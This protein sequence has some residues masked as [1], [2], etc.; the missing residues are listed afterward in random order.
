VRAA[1]RALDWYNDERLARVTATT[2][3]DS[4]SAHRMLGLALL[5]AGDQQAA[6]EEFGRALAIAPNDVVSLYQSA[7]IFQGAQRDIQALTLYRRTVDTDPTFLPGWLGLA[8]TNRESG[9]Y[10]PSLSNADKV[11]ELRP[12]LPHGYVA[13]GLAQA[14]L[15]RKEEARAS[16][17]RAVQVAPTFPEAL[18]AL[19][20][21]G[22]RE[23]DAA[24]AA[25]AFE[26]LVAVAPSA[27]AY[28]ALVASY[29]SAGRGEDADRAAAAARQRFP[30]DPAFAP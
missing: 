2:A 12:D 23:G 24:L 7:L 9:R 4:V 11:V 28:K 27:D 8:R 21:F 10:A 22:M 19:G 29:R 14:A 30:D 25:G 13:R 17:E 18:I 3:P 6:I 26:K 16:L 1:Y 15:D 5:G 20:S